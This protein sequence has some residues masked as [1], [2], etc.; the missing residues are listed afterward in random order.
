MPRRTITALATALTTAA[1]LTAAQASAGVATTTLG[2]DAE[3]NAL[4]ASKAFA[5]EGRF[6]N[7]NANNGDWEL[8]LWT[9]NT[10]ADQSNFAW[11]SGS[12][13]NF[14]LGFNPSNNMVTFSVTEFTSQSWNTETVFSVEEPDFDTLL[15]R[16][17]ATKNGSDITLDNLFFNGQSIPGQSAAD[18]D[19]T[20]LGLL[21]ISGID[22]TEAFFLTGQ[23]TMNWSTQD[24]P[25][26]SHLAF[27]IKAIEAVPTTSVVPTP[28]AALAGLS[29]LGLLAARRRRRED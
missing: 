5:A 1:T 15:L 21:A 28:T 24:M 29:A 9:P 18:S 6:G 25:R 7:N 8:G 23:L 16:T 17:R 10:V 19:D 3:A 26:G 14:I 27:Q 12:P 11:T 22:T 4:T 13:V 20:G 2:S